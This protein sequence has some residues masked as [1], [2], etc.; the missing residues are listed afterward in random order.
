MAS[1]TFVDGTTPIVASWLND[2]NRLVYSGVFPSGT[3]FSGTTGKFNISFPGTSPLTLASSGLE[4]TNSVNNYFSADIQN[5]SNGVNASSDFVATADTGTDTTHYINM[6][7]NGSGFSQ[8]GWTINGALDGYLYTQDTNLSIGTAGAKYLSFFIGGTLAA[9]ERA[10]FSSAGNLLIGTTTDAATGVLQVTGN[11][12]LTGT[13]T[14]SS[15]STL[16]GLLTATGGITT[17]ANLTTTS[18]G[19]IQVTGTGSVISPIIN[20]GP[21][22]GFRN[23][24]ING[25]MRIDQRNNGASQT[26]PVTTPTYTVDRFYAFSTG[27]AVSGQRVASTGADQ[28]MYQ[29]TGA[30]SVTAIAFGQRIEATNIYDLANTTVTFSCKIANSLLTTVTWTAYNPT[31]TDNWAGRTQI[32]TGT[33]TVNST[34]TKYSAN[35]ALTT[36]AQGGLEIELTVGAQISGTWQIGEVQ[37]EAG[38]VATTFE[39]RPIGT[40]LALCQRYYQTYPVNGS[41]YNLACTRLA[42]GAIIGQGN[43]FPVTMRVV[44]TVGNKA[45]SWVNALPS[46]AGQASAYITATD[47]FATISG[48]FTD[49]T[50]GNQNSFSVGFT[51]GTSFS[52]SAGQTVEIAVYSP[53][54]F[55]AEL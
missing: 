14:V 22:A 26:I 34:L 9:N 23:R 20:G 44:P 19:N 3:I 33:F 21:Q 46:S 54:T 17:P 13:F 16:T 51:A 48:A 45:T 1:T 32:A 35:I 50:S 52:S 36:A 25:D 38:T 55:T 18:T 6:G 43:P 5:Q 47:T 31:A 37:L 8:A 28:Y 4:I 49:I 40:E 27:A 11:T 7:I 30:A 10:R 24:I 39:R 41:S 53:Y 12:A 29:I 42:G 15:T 2:V